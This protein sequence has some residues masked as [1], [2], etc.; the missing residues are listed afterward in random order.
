MPFSPRDVPPPFSGVVSLS[1]WVGRSWHNYHSR[2]VIQLSGAKKKP[3]HRRT[4]P[5][6]SFPLAGVLVWLS[7]YRLKSRIQLTHQIGVLVYHMERMFV[8]TIFYVHCQK[9]DY[10]VFSIRVCAYSIPLLR[11]FRFMLRLF[12]SIFSGLNHNFSRLKTPLT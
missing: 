2:T 1:P 11:S 8:N 4:N 9:T 3:V 12:P 6:G 10:S 7:M 5:S